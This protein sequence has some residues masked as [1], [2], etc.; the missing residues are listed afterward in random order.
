MAECI[1][2]KDAINEA[3]VNLLLGCTTHTAIYADNVLIGRE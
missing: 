2:L 3:K 1:K